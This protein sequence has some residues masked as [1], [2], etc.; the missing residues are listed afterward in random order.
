MGGV[1]DVQTSEALHKMAIT[2]PITLAIV[3]A[4]LLDVAGHAWPFR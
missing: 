3:S 4:L 2:L 1:I